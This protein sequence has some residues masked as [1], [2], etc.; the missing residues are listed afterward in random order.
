MWTNLARH[1]HLVAAMVVLS[2]CDRHNPDTHPDPFGAPVF[3]YHLA[4]ARLW[5]RRN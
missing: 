1:A 2:K 3:R 5:A 4:A